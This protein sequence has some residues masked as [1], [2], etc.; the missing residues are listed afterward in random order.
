MHII[1]IKN[2]KNSHFIPGFN[3][4]K[5]ALLKGQNRIDMLWIAEG[6]R[7]YRAREI[8]RMAGERDIPVQF[9][10]SPILDKL[11]T[12]I[13]HQGIVALA[14]K[15]TYFDLDYIMDISLADPGHALIIMAD[16]ITDEGNLG[17]LIRTAVF[18]GAHGLILPKDR[19]ASVTERVRKRSAGAYVHLPVTRVVNM[20]RALDILKKKGFWVIGAAGEGPEPVYQFDWNRDLVLILGSED[21]G[22]SRSARRRCHQLVSIPSHGLVDSLNISVAGGVI[23]SE[24]IRQRGRVKD[25]DL[26]GK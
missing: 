2:K 7:S 13:A 25:E 3:A 21:R 11:M 24:I 17:A 15:F 5:E 23:L 18:F 22:L 16:H 1:G 19:S 12:G 10:K 8:I 14:E 9:K 20:G 26:S 4:V 6:K